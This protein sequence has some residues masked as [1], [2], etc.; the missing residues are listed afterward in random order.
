MPNSL[1]T[2]GGIKIGSKREGNRFKY[3]IRSNPIRQEL[4]V[5]T[6]GFTNSPPDPNLQADS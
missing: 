1:A 6:E 2:A 5:T 3:P 4:S